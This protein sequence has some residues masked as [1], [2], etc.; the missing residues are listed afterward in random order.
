MPF[1][2]VESRHLIRV[3]ISG[4]IRADSTSRGKLVVNCLLTSQMLSVYY[5][6]LY[7]I[8]DMVVG[9]KGCLERICLTC[10]HHLLLRC[11]DLARVCMTT[12]FGMT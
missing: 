2:T 5:I 9:Y 10:S 11:E 12:V 1:T 6:H 7:S 8:F 4:K 3:E